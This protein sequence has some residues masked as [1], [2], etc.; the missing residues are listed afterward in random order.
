M[1]ELP[2]EADFLH[3]AILEMESEDATAVPWLLCRNLRQVSGARLVALSYLEPQS[4]T[5]GLLALD[6]APMD[7]GARTS[8]GGSLEHRVLSTDTMAATDLRATPTPCRARGTEACLLGKFEYCAELL[9]EGAPSNCYRFGIRREGRAT[10]VGCM[11]LAEGAELRAPGLTAALARLGTTVLDRSLERR[12]LRRNHERLQ[13]LVERAG[14]WVWEIDDDSRFVFS[15][16]V[17]ETMI[18]YGPTELVGQMRMRDLIPELESVDDDDD[19]EL[20][21]S[22]TPLRETRVRLEVPRQRRDG[23][24]A[25]METTY[26]PIHDEDGTLRGF[27]GIDTDVTARRLAEDTASLTIATLEDQVRQRTRKIEETL[28]NIR[29]ALGGTIQAMARTVETRDPYTAGHQ[30]RV[31]DLARSIATALG[32]SAQQIDTVRMSASIHDLGKIA[33]PAEIWGKPGKL[34]PAEYAL[35]QTHCR[36]GHDILEPVTFPWPVAEVVLQHHERLDGTGYP[37][38]LTAEGF[39]IEARVLAVADVVEAMSSHRP[40]RASLGVGVALDEIRR[41]RGT[42]YDRDVVD[43]CVELFEKQDYKWP[44]R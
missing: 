10:L 30:R 33:I 23:T 29:S 15:N 37:D 42:R 32:M 13:Q 22:F 18:G 7:S 8:M 28:A 43:A 31:A 26:E 9:P 24:I 1:S 27:R 40:Y 44:D 21:L 3:D 35:I 41:H 38:G 16:R 5:L 11:E 19:E 12:Q 2:P 25:T 20:S 14:Q 4:Q 17:S 34:T 6:G 36:L 39:R